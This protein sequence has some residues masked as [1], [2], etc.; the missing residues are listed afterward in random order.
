MYVCIC[1]VH[2]VFSLNY[3]DDIC[4]CLHDEAIN[5]RESGRGHAHANVGVYSLEAF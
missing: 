4:S 1:S 5:L 2:F 3:V